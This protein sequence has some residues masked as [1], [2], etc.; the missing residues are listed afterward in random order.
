[1]AFRLYSIF[2]HYRSKGM[3]FGKELVNIKF[4]LISMENMGEAFLVLRRIQ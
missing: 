3:I 1:V 4:V 2:P